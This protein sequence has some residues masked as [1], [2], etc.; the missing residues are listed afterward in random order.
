MLNYLK[1]LFSSQPEDKIPEPNLTQSQ[2]L[3]VKA[4]YNTDEFTID[5]LLPDIIKMANSSCLKH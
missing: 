2:K 4:I 3:L 5:K 1:K